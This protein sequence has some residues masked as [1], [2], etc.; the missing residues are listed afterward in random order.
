M[1]EGIQKWFGEIFN[2][3]LNGVIFTRSTS[4]G[5]R[6]FTQMIWENVEDIGCSVNF[7]GGELSLNNRIY[8]PGFRHPRIF[9]ERSF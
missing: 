6:H 5:V 8:P 9:H 3:G 2:V 4:V 7:C 1:T